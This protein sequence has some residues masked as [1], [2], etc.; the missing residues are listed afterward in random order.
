[1]IKLVTHAN[2][3]HADDV[4]AY[5][6]LKEVLTKRGE[7][8]TITRSREREVIDQGDIVFDIGDEFDP[9]RHRYDH[10]QKERAGMRDNGIYYASAGLIWKY[11]GRELCSNE[12]VWEFVDKKLMCE[13][14]AVDNGQTY[15]PKPLF[16]N[17]GYAD[18]GDHIAWFEPSMFEPK[19]QE[20]LLKY[21]EEASEF[22]RGIL[23]RMIHA[24]EMAERA[25]AELTAIYNSSKVKEILVCDKN[26]ERGI[27][28]RA[29]DL[30]RATYIVY[31]NEFNNTW[32]VEC[33]P[34][35]R[36]VLESRKLLPKSWWGLRGNDMA[37]ATGIS[38]AFFCHASGFLMG[39]TSKEGA[40]KAAQIA[41][42][43]NE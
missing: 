7:T 35:V 18:M 41:L 42:V 24:A 38:D 30:P 43:S 1:M 20:T 32:K 16:D 33:V 25:F 5:A 17:A 37:Q 36:G 23:K 26:Y 8:W 14:D 10:H 40:I 29:A 9:A 31:P 2:G 21:F 28:R 4:I 27:W 11:F 13:M 6:I 39:T 15:M 3:F 22:M 12:A 34:K 19:D